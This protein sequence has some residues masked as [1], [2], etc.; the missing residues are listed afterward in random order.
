MDPRVSSK[1]G[2]TA[3]AE[4]PWF[5]T[6]GLRTRA[7]IPRILYTTWTSRFID[8]WVKNL[9]LQVLKIQKM[10]L[11]ENV[12]NSCNRAK[13]ILMDCSA[14]VDGE[15][16][17]YRRSQNRFFENIKINFGVFWRLKF[18]KMHPKWAPNVISALQMIKNELKPSFWRRKWV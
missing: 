11:D 10:Q 18:T 14:L 17:A 2:R 16:V 5:G 15:A 3:R 1:R 12:E 6:S 9:T 7:W 13:F 4:T 8:F